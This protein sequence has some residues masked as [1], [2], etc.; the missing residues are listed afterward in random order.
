MASMYPNRVLGFH[1]T[2]AFPDLNGRFV[3]RWA[4]TMLMPNMMLDNPELDRRWLFSFARGDF[5]WMLRESGYMHLQSTKPDTVATGLND[6]PAGLAAYLLEKYSTRP[7]DGNLVMWDGALTSRY[8]LDDLLT[9]MSLYWFNQNIHTSQRFYKESFENYE[10]KLPITHS[11]PTGITYLREAMLTAPV[12]FLRPTLGN[13]VY[14]SYVDHG[15]HF[16]ALEDPKT[17]AEEVVKFIHTCE[18][19]H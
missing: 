13:L 1:T 8:S 6:S 12:S 11:V 10:E 18:N 4:L 2:T 5:F 16:F 3:V 7:E 19:I 14:T 15:G 17:F 9:I